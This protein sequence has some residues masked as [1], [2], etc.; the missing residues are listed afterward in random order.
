[1][2]LASGSQRLTLGVFF[3]HT[4]TLFLSLFLFFETGSYYVD[5]TGLELIEAG[6][7]LP[8]KC[9]DEGAE[10]GAGEMAQLLRALTALPE[11]LSSIPS[12]H[13]VAHNHL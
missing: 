3:N 4:S 7:H 6:L 8:F 9:W 10:S 2:L 12:N 5:Q 11:V 13:M 1:M